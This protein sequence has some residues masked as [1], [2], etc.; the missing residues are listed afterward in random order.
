LNT[1]H[2]GLLAILYA[3]RLPSQKTDHFGLA[4]G[5]TAAL[6]PAFAGTGLTPVSPLWMVVG[7]GGELLVLWSLVSLGKRFGIAPADRG[8]VQAGPYRLVRHPMYLGELVLRLALAVGSV[9]ALIWLPFM[10]SLQILR[11]VRE[12]HILSGYAP[13]AQRVRWRLIPFIF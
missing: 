8:L 5:L 12:E 13:Y 2:N 3:T 9:E 11:A 7:V 4:L 1:A 10:L 6:L